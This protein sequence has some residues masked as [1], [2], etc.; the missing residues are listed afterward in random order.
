MFDTYQ[1]YV[2]DDLV[3]SGTG[4]REPLW[5]IYKFPEKEGKTFKLIINKEEGQ[6]KMCIKQ[7]EIQIA[8]IFWSNKKLEYPH[9]FNPGF[10]LPGNKL[11]IA[12]SS[13]FKMIS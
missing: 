4:I 7:M 9:C 8:G 5:N 12:N 3:Q 10:V 11:M 1:L 2:D 13:Y 6:P